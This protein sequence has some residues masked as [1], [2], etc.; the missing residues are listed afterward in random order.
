M[1]REMCTYLEW[2]LNVGRLSKSWPRLLSA[3]P[4]SVIPSAPPRTPLTLFPA[5]RS[6]NTHRHPSIP[7]RHHS[8]PLRHL[9]CHRF[10]CPHR[11]MLTGQDSSRKVVLHRFAPH[12][13]FIL[14]ALATATL[15]VGGGRGQRTSTKGEAAC[16]AFLPS[17]FDFSSDLSPMPTATKNKPTCHRDLL[18]CHNGHLIVAVATAIAACGALCHAQAAQLEVPTLVPWLDSA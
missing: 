7:Q 12:P 9:P 8:I 17:P 4:G 16:A 1:E 10:R 2:Q 18:V 15:G 13:N 11:S 5:P 14:L 6:E 3:N